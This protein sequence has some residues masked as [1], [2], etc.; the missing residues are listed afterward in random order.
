MLPVYL[1]IS[2][3]L[4]QRVNYNV[5][6]ILELF[7]E[8]CKGLDYETFLE[9]IFPPFY[10]RKNFERCK[11][12]VFEI[13][14][15]V[16][17]NYER[18]YLKPI[19][20]YPLF[21]LLNWWQNVSVA[22]FDITVLSDEIITEDDK[23]LSEHI[24]DIAAYKGFLFQDW[25]FLNL[26]NYFELY[27]QNPE[28]FTEIFQIDLE[29]Y[30]ELMPSDIAEEFKL[31]SKK[32]ESTKLNTDISDCDLEEYI[33]KTIY[34]A[35]RKLEQKPREIQRIGEVE[36]S[37]R[38]EANLHQVLNEKGIIITR[39]TPAGFSLKET[40]ELDFYIYDYKN[41]IYRTI[42]IGENKEWGEYPNSIKQ[43]IGYLDYGIS[44]GF[45]IIFNKSTRLNTII[46][47]RKEIL[48][49]FEVDG[50]FK[51]VGEIEDVIG[52]INVIKTKH[53]NPELE[54]SYFY[55]YHYIVNAF[56]PE[57]EESAKQA[58]K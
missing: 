4:V 36:L 20:E 40:G 5:Y 8:S 45:T 16:L 30:L 35:I 41:S 14:E 33:T 58:R 25:D 51:V 26:P 21:M 46:D 49:S 57:R 2:K 11:E 1:D 3:S 48:K 31:I 37:N 34:N 22:D 39:E 23:Y 53:E 15:M 47:R 17:D 18:T 29:D 50:K 32:D 12:I 54:G 27:K 6:L 55:L 19:Y 38:I 44:F 28:F 56:A 7:F 24:N 10:L 52:M 43:L 42:S 13:N 9:D